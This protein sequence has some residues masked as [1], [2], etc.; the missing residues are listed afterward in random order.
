MV[1]A[2]ADTSAVARAFLADEADHAALKDLL[3]TTPGAAVTSDLTRIELSAAF[4][5]AARAGRISD[6]ER[7]IAVALAEVSR[8]GGLRT[9]NLR[10]GEIENEVHHL[11]ARHRLRAA[12][13]IHLATAIVAM[14]GPGGVRF[15]TRDRRQAEAARAE[16]FEVI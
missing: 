12:D 5:R 10:I 1:I 7:L 14:E 11:L 4:R 8:S 15:V 2:Y 13:A 6:P 3:F 9:V 16:G